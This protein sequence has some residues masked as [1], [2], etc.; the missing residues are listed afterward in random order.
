MRGKPTA[1]PVDHIVRGGWDE[2]DG[3]SPQ[4]PRDK[5]VW[6]RRTPTGCEDR[7]YTTHLIGGQMPPGERKY[8]WNHK[9]SLE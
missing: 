1:G 3:L 7:D 9:P 8:H 2:E 4:R 5:S 6:Q